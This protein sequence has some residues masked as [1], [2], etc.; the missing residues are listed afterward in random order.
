MT[1][2]IE[3]RDEEPADR[4]D[5]HDVHAEAFGRPDEADLVDRLRDDG[6][7][8]LSLVAIRRRLLGSIVFTEVSFAPPSRGVCGVGLA[9]MAVRPE[10]QGE[11]IGSRLV[12][13]GLSRAAALGY[14]I[15]V[16]LGHPAYYPRFGFVAAEALGLECE[17]EVPAGVFMA[18]A[19]APGAEARVR[20]VVRYHPAFY[21]A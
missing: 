9:P 1:L 21:G 6:A 10:A 20:G 2:Q 13:E 17:W 16:V 5:V 15:A 14:E 7:I 11:G 8:V 12:R 19:L 3:I 18:Q 4:S